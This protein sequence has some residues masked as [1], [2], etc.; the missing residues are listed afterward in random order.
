MSSLPENRGSRRPR[1]SSRTSTRFLET[2]IPSATQPTF[3]ALWLAS[4]GTYTQKAGDPTAVPRAG[5]R[6]Y[7][8]TRR[9]Q[10]GEGSGR[11]GAGSGWYKQTQ[12]EFIG[13]ATQTVPSDQKRRLRLKPFFY[14]VQGFTPACRL[15]RSCLSWEQSPRSHPTTWKKD[16]PQEERQRNRRQR[17]II[18]P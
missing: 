3:P 15:R 8:P 2:P 1:E 6:M 18:Q 11:S 16:L 17:E 10:K 14:A 9:K 5:E 13:N 12:S 4:V 7:V